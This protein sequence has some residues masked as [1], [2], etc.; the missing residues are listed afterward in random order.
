ML[1]V[2]AHLM[3]GGKG[4]EERDEMGEEM[5]TGE[6]KERINKGEST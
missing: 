6:R 4:E 1:H 5:A 3:R 2:C